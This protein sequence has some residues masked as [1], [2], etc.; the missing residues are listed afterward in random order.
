MVYVYSNTNHLERIM[1]N[2]MVS[3]P[4]YIERNYK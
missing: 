2:L 4:L 3:L 1:I